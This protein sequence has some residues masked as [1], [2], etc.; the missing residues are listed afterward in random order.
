VKNN[1]KLVLLIAAW[2]LPA[3]AWSQNYLGYSKEYIKKAIAAN[4]KDMKPPVEVKDGESNYLIFNKTD[5]QRTVIYHFAAMPVIIDSPSRQ[6]QAEI[7]VK[8]YSKNKCTDYNACPQM[9]QVMRS[10]DSHFEK[11]GTY[12]Q[13]IDESRR[14]PQEWVLVRD[15]DYF[16]VHVMEMR[17]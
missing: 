11:G 4:Y 1:L 16:E 17:K 12:L 14:T 10:L 3:L 2:M 15:D 6:T 9:D 7:C 13:W 5:G 8:Y